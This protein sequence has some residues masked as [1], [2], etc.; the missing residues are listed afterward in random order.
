MSGA[1]LGVSSRASVLIFSISHSEAASRTLLRLASWA[2]HTSH[3][4]TENHSGLKKRIEM[5][6]SQSKTQRKLALLNR[7]VKS[8]MCRSGSF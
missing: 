3:L 1:D 6:W 2:W 4:L 5:E 7:Q 8:H